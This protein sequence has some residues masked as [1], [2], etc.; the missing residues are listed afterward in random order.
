M[1]PIRFLI[2]SIFFLS[3]AGAQLNP[4]NFYRITN[5]EGLSQATVNVM[6]KD[7][8]GFLW[9][10]TDDGL[11]RFDGNR[12]KTYYHDF[13][14]T[15]T[16][17]ANEVYGICE[18]RYNRIW[19]A[20]YNAG[21]SIFDRVNNKFIRLYDRL[22]GSKRFST[23][24]VYG[25]HVDC[26]GFIWVRTV[27]GI[28]KI[29]PDDLSVENFD[30]ALFSL[31]NAPNISITE[32]KHH[33]FFGSQTS[34]LLAV[35]KT[36]H[37]VNLPSWSVDRN[38]ARVLG[39][40]VDEEQ[41][42]LIASEKGLY[43]INCDNNNFSI[44]L[45]IEDPVIFESSN[46]LFRERG[47]PFVWVAT[48]MGIVVVDIDQKKIVRHIR[49]T[50]VNDNL[51][52]N[53]VS[54]LFQDSE[55]NIFVGTGR[56]VNVYS[57]SSSVFNKY[58]NVLRR[59]PGFGHPV[60]AIHEL[61]NKD[62]LLG[63]KNGGAYYFNTDSL[64]LKSIEISHPSTSKPLKVY[65]IIP[66]KGKDYLLCTSEG[67]FEMNMVEN[68]VSAHLPKKHF[69]L[70][71]LEEVMINHLLFANDS[72][73][74]IASSTTGFYKWNYLSRK[75]KLYQKNEENPADGPVDNQVLKLIFTKEKDII[76]CTK[77]GVSIYYPLKDSFSNI[78][79]GKSY[80]R[81]LVS[82]N[83]KDAW[84]DGNHIWFA[85]FGAGV[86]K[87]SKKTH[88]FTKL[89][90][91]EGL[92]NNSVYAVVPDDIGNVWMPTNRGLAVLNIKKNTIR[93][94]TT[95]D[96][97]PDNEFNGYVS[98][99]ARGGNLYFSTINGIVNA[100]PNLIITNPVPP[101]IVLTHFEVSGEK[102]DSVYNTF[103]KSK[104]IV[105]PGFNSLY[106]E[107]AA[108]SFAAPG[109]N[110]FR[111]ILENYDKNW[112]DLRYTSSRRY[113]KIPPG[114]YR[115]RISGSNNSGVWSETPFSIN[116]EIVPFWY[117][118]WLFK[119]VIMLLA[120]FAVVGLYRYRVAHILKME[121]LRRRISSD[122]HDDI[123]STL[124]SINIYSEL[125]KSNRDNHDY[126]T[127][128]QQQTQNIIS[129][130]DDLVWTINPK[131]DNT[132]LLF[133][134]MNSFAIPLLTAKKINWKFNTNMQ[135]EELPL[136]PQQRRT[137]FHAFKE[138]INNAIKY[139]NCSNCTIHLVKTGKKLKMG[140]ED[141][142]HGFDVDKIKS[143]RNGL[144]NLAYRS[145]E[146]NGVFTV[147]SSVG[148][149]TSVFIEMTI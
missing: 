91:K 36:G 74:Y 78:L 55:Q 37:P 121:E 137:L 147:S 122:L 99:K 54:C 127:T 136:T 86:Q 14:D 10:G 20:H 34:G 49:S 93:T 131:N 146:L 83:I 45:I 130:L 40:Y 96:G 42:L 148:K 58:D 4:I 44:E 17:A 16:M 142:G 107:F 109:K 24:R 41:Q 50:A 108:L 62:L 88:L 53:V 129:N 72:L 1:K 80:P 123:G 9:I 65:Q 46:K 12:I 64:R 102:H 3:N 21:I 126:V 87:M 66:D 47:K 32:F 71:Q 76:L 63:T 117:E 68:M 115:L 28:S 56:G 82:R 23:N 110:Q 145:K 18:D 61:K 31:I 143:G 8:Q 84:D 140:V 106:V 111:I 5:T 27:F 128:I 132:T 103:G 114:K 15:T 29:N 19:I 67:I 138:M 52:S 69:E 101:P 57:P 92:P 105:P 6:Y 33:M 43:K 2:A 94:Y 30:H 73:A 135:H 113:T 51:V 26:K 22:K 48:D 100:Q 118:T 139:S 35:S 13:L 97:L 112:V 98:H 75:L 7:K 60:Y 104:V 95:D 141:D 144:C 89:T 38:G 90:V 25:L 59:I 77:F 85:T 149:G 125:A 120:V 133:E 81:E 116:I 124:S 39:M 134:K 79:P 119:A 11:N 70:L